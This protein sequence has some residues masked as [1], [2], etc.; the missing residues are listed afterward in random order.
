[1]MISYVRL[2]AYGV[3]TI[4]LVGSGCAGGYTWRSEIATRNKERCAAD[5]KLGKVDRCPTEIKDAFVSLGIGAAQQE[6]ENAQAVTGEVVQGS[7][8]LRIIERQ[9]VVDISALAAQERT[10]ACSTSPAIVLR[11]RQLQ[12]DNP[13]P[14]PVEPKADALA[15]GAVRVPER[16]PA[17]D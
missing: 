4:I 14:D 9:T 5:I 17:L 10:H 3:A 11:R 1:M 2:A 15:S 8:T 13:A 16:E 6:T 7:D 12:R